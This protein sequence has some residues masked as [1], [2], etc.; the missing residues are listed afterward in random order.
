MRKSFGSRVSACHPRSARSKSPEFVTATCS[1]HVSTV[2][3]RTASPARARSSRS[4]SATRQ[5]L[6]QVRPRR[7]RHHQGER[8]PGRDARGGEQPS[9]RLGV[10]DELARPC[11]VPDEGGREDAVRR[12]RVP[13][14]QPDEAGAVDRARE[15][16]A[17]AGLVERGPLVVDGEVH[18]V[19]A[20]VGVEREAGSAS[21]RLHVLRVDGG[22][23]VGRAAG[24]RLRERRGVG[25]AAERD[26]LEA[27]RPAPVAGVGDELHAARPN[28]LDAEGAGADRQ[29]GRVPEPAR[30]LQREE[31]L[32]QRRQQRRVR[33]LEHDLHDVGPDPLRAPGERALAAGGAR[34]SRPPRPR[35]TAC[36]RGT[37]RLRA[38]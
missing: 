37:R 19:E 20:G 12:L 32:R 2:R 24:E 25:E 17:H 36:R 8:V 21:Q 18:E 31:R 34:S 1:V 26:A 15:G 5:R 28:R 6:G 22:R 33:A 30:A 7:P 3:S 35:R 38:A 13:A 29:R 27:R 11:V 10:E 9:R 14:H 23:H 4:R 16:L